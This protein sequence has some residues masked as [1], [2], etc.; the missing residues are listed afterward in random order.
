MKATRLVKKQVKT[1][2]EKENIFIPLK[3]TLKPILDFWRCNTLRGELK[4]KGGSFNVT[5]YL[6]YLEAIKY[7]V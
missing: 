1:N 3:P 5:L 4:E 2:L 7:N 6:D